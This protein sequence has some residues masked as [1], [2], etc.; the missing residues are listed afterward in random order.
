MTSSKTLQQAGHIYCRECHTAIPPGW[1][2][3]PAC[4]GFV[5]K[6][7][8][9]VAPNGLRPKAQPDEEQPSLF[10]FELPEYPA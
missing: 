3:C 1:L 10:A 8:H 9:W 7:G 4:A 5:K 6:C 2:G